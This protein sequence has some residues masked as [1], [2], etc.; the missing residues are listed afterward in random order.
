[1]KETNREPETEE[2]A[3]YI[4]TIASP[5]GFRDTFGIHAP[6][7]DFARRSAQS[8]MVGTHPLWTIKSVRKV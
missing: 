7:E 8:Q 1:M 3:Y 5:S 4:V 6:N 2:M